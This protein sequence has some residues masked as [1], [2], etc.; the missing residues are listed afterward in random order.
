MK[1]LTITQ[2]IIILDIDGTLVD[3]NRRK[4]FCLQ[5]VLQQ[6]IPFEKVKND[7]GLTN[8]TLT[9]AQRKEFFSIFLSGKYIN[10][11]E[12]GDTPYPD[13]V[14]VVRI[15]ANRYLIWY[16][17]GRHDSPKEN[18]TMKPETLVSL[19]N[20]GFPEVNEANVRLWMK[21]NRYTRDLNFKTEVVQFIATQGKIRAIVGN[22]PADVSEEFTEY[23]SVLI[24]FA[25]PQYDFNFSQS[26][27]LAT[28][29]LEIK[30]ILEQESVV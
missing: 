17:T 18:D 6:E 30:K 9:P 22:R 25:E 13:A 2:E 1:N 10:H 15:L 20:L 26:V 14:E 16:V 8:F 27:K 24:G 28:S 19:S 5:K 11:P 23:T 12:Y 21:S 3:L 7:Y 4:W 29:W